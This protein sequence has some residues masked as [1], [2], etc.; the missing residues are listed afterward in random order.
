MSNEE[1][2]QTACNLLLQRVANLTLDAVNLGVELEDARA[3]VKALQAKVDDL[4]PAP[5]EAP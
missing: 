3:Q 4:T 1:K 2:L 5:K